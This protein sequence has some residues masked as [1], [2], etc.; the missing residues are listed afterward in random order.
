M[1]YFLGI[2]GS[3][4]LVADFEEG[5]AGASPGLNHPVT[6]AKVLAT[7]T[8]YH[9]AATYDGSKWRLYV[10]GVL[11]RQLAV[12]RPVRFDSIQRASI[13]SAQ[14]SA[15][16]AAGFFN[17]T[18][19][20]VR[21]WNV[22][23]SAS[24]IL[25]AMNSPLTSASGLVARWGIDEGTGT[26]V[27]DS[28]GSSATG[29]A[30]NGPVWV[31][32]A[33][34]LN[35]TTNQPPVANAGQDIA[36]TMPVAASLNGQV[37]DDVP[38]SVSSTWSKFSGPGT[39]TFGNVGQLVTTASFS[40]SGTYVLR[41]TATD[42][43]FTATDDVTIQVNAAVPVNQPPVVNAGPDGSDYVAGCVDAE[44]IGHRRQP[45]GRAADFSWSQ[46]SGQVVI[47]AT[48]RLPP[49]RR[50]FRSL[51]R[52]AALARATACCRRPTP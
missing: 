34:A 28:S 46:T 49:H 36:I 50:R 1:N 51:E 18:I 35:A 21:I 4:H 43:Q 33:P 27:G 30:R 15:G 40:T 10:N 45:S 14:D 52:R 24:A 32:G 19:D 44:R 47:L 41:L 26:T 37:T 23:R 12:G 9:A 22:A 29:T 6:G 31:P 39:V 8:W 11:D 3:G 25:S 13:A 48:R 7:N 38:S 17:G 20:E 2:D 5:A 42:G 16:T